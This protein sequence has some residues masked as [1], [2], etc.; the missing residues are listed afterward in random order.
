MKHRILYTL[1]FLACTLGASAQPK[2]FKKARKAQINLITYD[3]Q[4]Q[5]LHATNG[6]FI[7]DQ[8]TA[9]TDY[10]SFRG[11]ARAVAIDE[12]G[13]EWPVSS[14]ASLPAANISCRS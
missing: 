2:W 3:A 6:F 5:L 12:A 1:L 7:D 11:A 14:I 8:G 13:K 9:L 10:H 4:G